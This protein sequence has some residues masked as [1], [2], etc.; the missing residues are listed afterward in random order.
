MV[1]PRAPRRTRGRRTAMMTPTTIPRPSLGGTSRNHEHDYKSTQGLLGAD[2]QTFHYGI[3]ARMRNVSK[4]K[5]EHHEAHASPHA[6]RHHRGPT[7]FRNNFTR[8][9][10]GSS[11]FSSVTRRLARGPDRLSVETI[12]SFFSRSFTSKTRTTYRERGSYRALK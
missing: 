8:P 7:P 5:A 10:H 6:H 3:C 9:Y 4:Y 2:A 11:N 12:P 1:L